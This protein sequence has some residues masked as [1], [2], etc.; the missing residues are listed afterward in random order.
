MSKAALHRATTYPYR[1]PSNSYIFEDGRETPLGGG[2]FLPELDGRVPVLAVGSNQSPEQL[3][4][5]FDAPGWG[6]IP[7]IRVELN[8]FDSVYSPHITT[9]GAIAATLH[10]AASAT[11]SLFVNWLTPVQLTRMHETELG[12]ENY[13]FGA[14]NDVAIKAEVGPALTEVHLYASNHGALS[15][16][17]HPVPLSEI[18]ARGRSW[19]AMAQNEVQ[20]HVRDHLA[21]D[22]PLNDFIMESISDPRTRRLRTDRLRRKSHAFA[23]SNWRALPA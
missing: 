23:H 7:T 5:K 2:A 20:H 10:Q 19:A 1:I 4:R 22:K 8:G 6:A 14:L 18:S 11:V 3:A 9:Y 13:A 12:N 16:D 15:H 17:G 21:A